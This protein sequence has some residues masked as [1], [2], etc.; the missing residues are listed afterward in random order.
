MVSVGL[1]KFIKNKDG[2]LVPIPLEIQQ[3]Q[4]VAGE[5]NLFSYYA[6]NFLNSAE[7]MKNMLIQ[8]GNGLEL[9]NV[10]A[11]LYLHA[12]ELILKAELFN[13]DNQGLDSDRFGRKYGH[14][15]NLLSQE[16]ETNGVN[17]KENLTADEITLIA[18]TGDDYKSKLYN[19]AN[20]IDH[21]NHLK[22]DVISISNIVDK[23]IAN[24]EN[25]HT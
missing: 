16:L 2:D 21:S 12:L 7:A 10:P 13:V 18:K 11:F 20:G 15:L 4:P 5:E 14:N 25:H 1:T 6:R 19:Y 3:I 23:I 17:W 22:I 8:E 24:L 9:G